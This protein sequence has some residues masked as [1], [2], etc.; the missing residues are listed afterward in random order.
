MTAWRRMQDWLV[1]VQGLLLMLIPLAFARDPG[2][3]GAWVCYVIGGLLLASGLWSA[4][5]AQA[6]FGLEWATPLLLA[7]LLTI[8]PSSLGYL[9][10]RLVAIGGWVTAALVIV[11]SLGELVLGPDLA[12]A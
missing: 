7:L 10:D 4:S 1:M 5:T 11:T 6:S 3:I 9:E 12:P 8:A 2:S